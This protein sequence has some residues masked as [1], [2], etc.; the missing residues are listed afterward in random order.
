M[1]LPDQVS[2]NKSPERSTP[3]W[4][5]LVG[6]PPR[7]VYRHSYGKLRRAMTPAERVAHNRQQHLKRKARRKKLSAH[8]AIPPPI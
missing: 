2:T 6:D 4:F 7:L 8:K 3:P 5:V 1:A